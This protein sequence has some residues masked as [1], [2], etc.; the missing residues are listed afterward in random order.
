MS[1]MVESSSDDGNMS[2]YD[3]VEVE[4]TYSS[5]D[6]ADTI[7]SSLAPPK[8]WSTLSLSDA[9]GV[10]TKAS[11]KVAAVAVNDA[12]RGRRE[13]ISSPIAAAAATSSIN[14][15]KGSTSSTRF[16]PGPGLTPQQQQQQQQQQHGCLECPTCRRLLRDCVEC[17]T[18][19]TLFCREHLRVDSNGKSPCPCAPCFSSSSSSSVSTPPERAPISTLVEATPTPQKLHPVESFL[20]NIPVQRMA[21]AVPS[22]CEGCGTSLSWGEL[23]LHACDQQL[24]P[25]DAAASGCGWYGQRSRLPD[26]A[27]NCRVV[28]LRLN[29][30]ARRDKIVR[31]ARE[32]A[33]ELRAGLAAARERASTAEMRALELEE[34]VA[35]AERSLE[36]ERAVFV[37]KQNELEGLLREEEK[38]T[39]AATT[40]AAAAAAAAAASSA[41]VKREQRKPAA[42]SCSSGG[43]NGVCGGLARSYPAPPTTFGGLF[44]N[45]ALYSPNRTPTQR[46]PICTPAVTAATAVK[47]ATTGASCTTPNSN[48]QPP[49]PIS[50]AIA[51]VARKKNQAEVIATA[52]GTQTAAAVAA[53]AS[54]ASRGTGPPVRSSSNTKGK[55]AHSAAVQKARRGGSAA[56]ASSGGVM[57]D[58]ACQAPVPASEACLKPY[59]E[60]P[61]SLLDKKVVVFWPRQGKWYAGRPTVYKEATKEHR[62]EYDDG[63][64]RDHVLAHRAWGLIG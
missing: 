55:G 45:S 47:A 41:A 4:A 52:E 20:P 32:E 8:D 28:Q 23:G 56:A 39:T 24:V 33:A 64:V 2:E 6:D 15:N 43:K 10:I 34:R 3:F 40:K 44:N 38:K 50:L 60:K 25:C 62:V 37:T 49:S 12:P 26:H 29:E 27:S 22:V 18:Y 13:F 48:K 30:E 7:T 31:E 9:D 11:V 17:P 57:M 42:A 63:D 35:R 46:I 16:E 59:L 54:T 21:D 61:S 58:T 51:A 36:K 19:H 14:K 53:V 1:G 5:S